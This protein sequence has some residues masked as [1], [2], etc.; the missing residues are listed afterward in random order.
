MVELP[1]ETVDKRGS[2]G[3][4]KFLRNGRRKNGG[5]AE[6]LNFRRRKTPD[7]SFY[8]SVREFPKS[9]REHQICRSFRID[10][11]TDQWFLSC[12]VAGSA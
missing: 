10:C 12:F 8:V 7:I 4:L 5:E 3:R 11:H 2:C 6:K 1:L 9:K